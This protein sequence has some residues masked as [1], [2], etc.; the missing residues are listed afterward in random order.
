MVKLVCVE[1]VYSGKSGFRKLKLLHEMEFPSKQDDHESCHSTQTH[2]SVGRQGNQVS[3]W[4]FLP[5]R[6]ENPRKNGSEGQ[7][8]L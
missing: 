2:T 6:G 7:G 1:T 5:G 4:N 3:K 8:Q